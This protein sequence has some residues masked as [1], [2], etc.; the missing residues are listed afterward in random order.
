MSDDFWLETGLRIEGFTDP[1][2]AEIIAAIP[3]FQAIGLLIQE[4]QTT[5]QATLA[6]AQ[7]VQAQSAAIIALATEIESQALP[8]LPTVNMILTKYKEK[9]S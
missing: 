1:Q 5:I 8:L 6:L 7:Q 3:K 2:I 4:K 9:T